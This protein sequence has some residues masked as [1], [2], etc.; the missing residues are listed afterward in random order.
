DDPADD[1]TPDFSPDSSQVI[2]RSERNG[3]GIYVVPALG[4]PARLI[5]AGGRGPRFSPDGSRIAYWTGGSRG[6][7]IANRS[8]HAFVMAL[9]GGTATP[10]LPDFDATTDPVWSPDGRSLIVAGRKHGSSAD[11]GFDWWVVTL[12]G[13]EPVKTGV[14]ELPRFRTS[15]TICGRW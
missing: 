13:K 5:A 9:S 2:F 14:L 10:L 7:V 12:D 3:G 6:Q 8:S 15:I 11:E 1:S 4:G